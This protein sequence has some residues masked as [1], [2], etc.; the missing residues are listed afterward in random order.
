MPQITPRTRPASY[1]AENWQ[2]LVESGQ[3][4]LKPDS[5]EAVEGLFVEQVRGHS[6]TMQTVRLSRG[7]KDTL[8][9]L[10][11]DTRRGITW[12]PLGS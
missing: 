12:L 3:L 4:E 9:F 11:Y 2:P 7:G 1:R 10:R 5:Y 6:E 8:W